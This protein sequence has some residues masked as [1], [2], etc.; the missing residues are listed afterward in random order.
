M[1]LSG[2]V[3]KSLSFEIAVEGCQEGRGEKWSM[4]RSTRIRD[5]SLLED[6]HNNY[7]G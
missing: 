2:L 4:R 7:D 6:Y 1:M 3:C 5:D